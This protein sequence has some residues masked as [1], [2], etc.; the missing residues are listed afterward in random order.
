[1]HAKM[2]ATTIISTCMLYHHYITTCILYSLES[3]LLI[4]S[5]SSSY[6]E[7]SYILYDTPSKYYPSPCMWCHY[8]SQPLC[9]TYLRV[10]TDQGSVITNVTIT[11]TLHGSCD[12]HLQL[13]STMS[14]HLTNSGVVYS[15]SS[16]ESIRRL[17]ST[18]D[19][20][21]EFNTWCDQELRKF[22]TD[23]DGMCGA[24]FPASVW[25]HFHLKELPHSRFLILHMVQTSQWATLERGRGRRER[26]DGR[27]W[28]K[29]CT[30]M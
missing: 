25:D 13:Y 6:Q 19:A 27:E 4:T 5:Y 20:R 11:W 23:V 8:A 24:S 22:N 21:S 17:L 2:A 16:Q 3:L 15:S 10:V 26:S 18:N 9:T 29:G 14:S 1:M 30:D 28:G 12:C 7:S